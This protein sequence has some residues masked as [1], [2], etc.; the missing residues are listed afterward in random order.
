MSCTRDDLLEFRRRWYTK[1]N[2]LFLAITPY[3]H[4]ELFEICS[5][6][7]ESHDLVTGH[8][9]ELPER[10]LRETKDVVFTQ[11]G[12]NQSTIWGV[13]E[14]HEY[15]KNH[16]LYNVAGNILGS[17]DTSKLFQR[18]RTK[19]GL[20]YA[21]NLF[22]KFIARKNGMGIVWFKTSQDRVQYAKQCVLE[23]FQEFASRGVTQQ[24]LD[25]T[26]RSWFND[27]CCSAETP[28]SYAGAIKTSYF[29]GAHFDPQK[30]W[31]GVQALSL[32][33]INDFIQNAF[34]DLRI[35]WVQMDP[36]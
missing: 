5:K 20:V 36:T 4:E 2:S 16:N 32:G 17:G 19:E 8:R 14:L 30:E 27:E 29:R 1:E 35:G 26:K 10:S 34:S 23:V 3:C 24:E 18:L 31:E 7:F 22:H 28:R 11:A 33:E 6:Y 13:L 12:I 21:V 25:D 15:W 9:Q